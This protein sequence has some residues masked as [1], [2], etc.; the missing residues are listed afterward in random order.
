MWRIPA[1][2]SCNDIVNYQVQLHNPT[3]N[4]SATRLVS[5][6]GTFFMLSE[7]HDEPFLHQ[8]TQIQVLHVAKCVIA[9]IIH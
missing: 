6:D 5:A 2:V 4:Q 7:E 3:L 8:D 1:E 9:L